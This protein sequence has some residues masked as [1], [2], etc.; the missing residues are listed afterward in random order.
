MLGE[1]DF[2][3]VC[4]FCCL[5]LLYQPVDED[6]QAQPDHVHEVPVPGNALEAE[7]ILGL[8]VAGQQRKKM[9]I[10]MVDAERHVEA[11]ETGQ[12]EEGRADRL[13]S[14]SLRFSSE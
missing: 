2:R 5:F 14:M 9:T 4:H 7:V 8:E 12:H 13:P 10:S 11:V 1:E 6:E 3:H